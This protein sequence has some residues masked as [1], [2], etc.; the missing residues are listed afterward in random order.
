MFIK[1]CFKYEIKETKK[2]QLH[3]YAHHSFLNYL[4]IDI[5]VCLSLANCCSWYDCEVSQNENEKS[6]W[7]SLFSTI[8]FRFR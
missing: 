8:L 7:R 4:L 2:L 3:S 5:A 1:I 6:K